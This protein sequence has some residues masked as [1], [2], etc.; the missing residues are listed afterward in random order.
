MS[1]ISGYTSIAQIASNILIYNY[2]L[3]MSKLTEGRNVRSN[4]N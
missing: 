1:H 4:A 2:K 3:S